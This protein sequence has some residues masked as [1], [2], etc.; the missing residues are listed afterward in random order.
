LGRSIDENLATAAVAS[1]QSALKRG[2]LASAGTS[3]REAQ[4]LNPGDGRARDGLDSLQKKAA[5]LLR[6]A[7]IQKDRD[8]QGAAEKLKVVIETAADGSETK[9]KAEMYLGE[10]Q[11]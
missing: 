10:L 6:E 4:R 2:D 1:G 8:P 7:Y 5:E 3:F 11:E 9:R